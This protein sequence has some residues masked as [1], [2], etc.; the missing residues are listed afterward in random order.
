[1]RRKLGTRLLLAILSLALP[2]CASADAAR[3]S[4]ATLPPELTVSG[5]TLELAGCGTREL[6]L[7][8]LYA[9]GLYVPRPPL[10]RPQILD[11]QTTKAVRLQVVYD[12]TVPDD[13]PDEWRARLTDM[14][15]Q[16]LI[17]TLQGFYREIRSGDQ[18]T[19]TYTPDSGTTIRINGESVVAK[20]GHD[21]IHAMLTLW[22]G[23]NAISGNLRQLLLQGSC[24][25]EEEGWF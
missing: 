6:M 5:R 7:M 13:I 25:S 14:V 12:G 3:I 2:L 11:P 17:R 8:D 22:I 15:R 18:V 20:P 19:I 21:L 16:D 1:M 24:K 4:G 23:D 9:I 10:Q